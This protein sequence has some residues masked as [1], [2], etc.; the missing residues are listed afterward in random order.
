MPTLLDVIFLA[1]SEVAIDRLNE[2]NGYIIITYFEYESAST[3]LT[4]ITPA[5]LEK[6]ISASLIRINPLYQHMSLEKA[7]EH[8]MKKYQK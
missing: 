8:Y 7:I 3:L 6:I 1:L 2:P 5:L 4:H